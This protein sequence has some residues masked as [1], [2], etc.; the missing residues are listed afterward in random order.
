M[1]ALL[2]DEVADALGTLDSREAD[3]IAAFAART[4]ICQAQGVLM[5][6]LH[7]T[8]NEAYEMLCYQSAP[9]VELAAHA[10]LLADIDRDRAGSAH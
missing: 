8:A 3:L 1:I 2:R 6:T 5:E 9:A 4:L 10:R 7:C